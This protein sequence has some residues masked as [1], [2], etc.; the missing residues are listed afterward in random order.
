MLRALG[1]TSLIKWFL[2]A[3]VAVAI[4]QSY[5][6][7]IGAI[8]DAIWGWVQDGATVVTKIWHSLM[9]HHH[10]AKGH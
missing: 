7:N 1:I 5:D 2:I 6:G 4:W 9:V 3:C 10:T 8:V